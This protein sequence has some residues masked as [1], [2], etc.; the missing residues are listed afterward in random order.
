MRKAK[1][2][3]ATLLALVFAPAMFGA[4]SLA[5]S[6]PVQA[7]CTGPGAPPNTQTKCLTAVTIPGNALRSFDISWDNPDRNEYY[8]G[9]RTNAGIV[10][11]DTGALTF[12]RTIGGFVGIKLLAGAVDNNHSGPDGVTSHGKWLYGGD[13]DSTLKVIDLTIPCGNPATDPKCTNP[14]VQTVSTG[15]STRVDE[16][17]LTTDGKLLLAA[18]NAED[19]PFG[20]LFNANGDNATSNVSK[21]V[22]IVVD[23]SIIPPGSGL[24]IEQPTWDPTTKRFYVSVPTIAGNPKGCNINGPAPLCEGG[25]LIIDPANLPTP[26]LVNGVLTSFIGLFD[27]TTNTG[28]L[29]LH[30]CGPNGSTLG[31]HDNLLLGCSPGN[32]P[33]NTATQV[34]NATTKNFA[35]IGNITGSDEV[36]F[37]AGDTRYYTGSSADLTTSGSRQAVLGVID[38]EINL[39]IEKIPQSTGSH[40]VAADCN[41]NLI[42]VP[43]AAPHAAVGS[44]GDTTAVGAGICG[45]ANDATGTGC[46]AVYQDTVIGKKNGKNCP[47]K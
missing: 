41:G 24:S 43:Q 9:E 39:L 2:A 35:N 26:V 32:V 14:L 30:E 33:T 22:R 44:G 15:G 37:N 34:I 5:T 18:N 27:P 8:L 47:K 6:N 23:A 42:F 11:I 38:A 29:P 12:K 4:F 1:S 40:S 21:I 13:G 45:T 46:V 31:P 25:L 7:Q 16:M 36:W 17:A 19:P 28:V 3:K 10:I 20:T